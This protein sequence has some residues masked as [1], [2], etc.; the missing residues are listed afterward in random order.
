MKVQKTATKKPL[1]IREQVY[2]RRKSDKELV[3]QAAELRDLSTS[4][5]M[6]ESSIKE[7]KRVIAENKDGAAA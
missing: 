3:R 4:Q 7:A 2:F 5:F 1:P 6:R